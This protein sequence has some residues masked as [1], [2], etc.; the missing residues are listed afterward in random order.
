MAEATSDQLIKLHSGG[1]ALSRA[2]L[3]Y[4]HPDLKA[5]WRE[6]HKHSALETLTRDLANISPEAGAT[7]DHLNQA[8]AGSRAILTARTDLEARLKSKI[9]TYIKNGYLHGFGYE[10]PRRLSAAPVA[11]PKSVWAGQC[12]WKAGQLSCRGLEF[13]DV[14]LTT[15]RIR[16]EIL[17]RGMADTT[18]TRPVG[19]PTV[20]PDIAAAFHA[21][22]AAG[23][24]DTSKSQKSHFPKILKWLELNRPD[25]AVPPKYLNDETIRK[26]VAPLFTALKQANKQ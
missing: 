3:A 25:L 7:L 26:N 21:L 16:N 12:D 15:N 17:E 13:V 18:P 2:W 4:A 14:R 24:I 11:I 6:L 5:E 19:R 23:E 8:T 1:V 22:N 20:G 10:L 9:L